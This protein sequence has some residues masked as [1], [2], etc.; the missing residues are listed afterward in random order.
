MYRVIVS[1][2]ED[3]N[4][5]TF[6]NRAL[7]YDVIN[8]TLHYWEMP[9]MLRG[10]TEYAQPTRSGEILKIEIIEVE[11]IP[12][13]IDPENE[14]VHYVLMRTDI[15]SY[16]CGRACAQV[17]HAGTKMVMDGTDTPHWDNIQ[18]WSQAGGGFGTCIVLGV[19]AAE[20][21]SA[22]AGAVLNDIHAGIVH[23]PSY[24]VYDGEKI[25]PIPLDTC[26][27]VF[28]TIKEC[29]PITGQFQ[30]LK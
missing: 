16:T 23:D 6:S 15:P 26:A 13:T 28:G 17:N 27:Y 22:V 20:M 25:V 8:A 9:E 18:A 7:I 30:L 2:A 10:T 14:L 24:P 11:E 3:V 29:K 12:E 21:R 4:E 19:N 1:K 5:L